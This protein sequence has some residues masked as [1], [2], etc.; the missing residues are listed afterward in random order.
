M[1]YRR[2][3]FEGIKQIFK[4]CQKLSHSKGRKIYITHHILPSPNSFAFSPVQTFTVL[5]ILPQCPRGP[6]P[7]PE[8]ACMSPAPS[9]GQDS[10][11]VGETFL[12][13]SC[14]LLSECDVGTS[15]AVVNGLAPG[16][17]GQDKGKTFRGKPGLVLGSV[18]RRS[19]GCRAWTTGPVGIVTGPVR[20]R[21]GDQLPA[22][23]F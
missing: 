10:I 22:L 23:T 16:S 11:N 1:S 18:Y 3:H 2:C 20:P 14:F 15:K 8:T 6:I 19:R 17:N 5:R 12:L 9:T 4:K 7:R 13:V 21:A